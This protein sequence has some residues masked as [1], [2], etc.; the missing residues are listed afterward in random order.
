[1]VQVRPGE[2]KLLSHADNLEK[3]ER[4][5]GAVGLPSSRQV[6]S[7]TRLTPTMT[8]KYGTRGIIIRFCA[9]IQEDEVSNYFT[10]RR[11]KKKWTGWRPKDDEAKI[12]FQKA[13]MRREDEKQEENLGTIEKGD[14]G[15]SSQS[16][17]QHKT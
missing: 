10:A 6:G 2:R 8:S 16:G 4:Q 11:R 13:V 17:T 15:G 9:V 5:E 3:K 14:R 7:R 12:E 1:M